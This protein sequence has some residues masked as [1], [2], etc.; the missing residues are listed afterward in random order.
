MQTGGSQKVSITESE[1]VSRVKL[2]CLLYVLSILYTYCVIE[3]EFASMDLAC[4]SDRRLFWLANYVAEDR[5]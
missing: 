4:F 3:E 5:S 2:L 1:D